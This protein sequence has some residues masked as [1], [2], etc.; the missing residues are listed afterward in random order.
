MLSHRSQRFRE[1]LADVCERLQPL[2]GCARRVLPFTASGTGGLEAVFVNAVEPGAHVLALSAGYFGERF[3]EIG[4]AHGAD[5]TLVR[6]PWGEAIEPQLLNAALRDAR[7][8][9]K[10]WDA[11]LLTHNETSTGVIHPLRDLCRVARETTDALVLVDAVSSVGA[12]PL[13]L[14][15]WGIDGAVTVSQKALMA[16]PGLTLL[17]VSDRLLKAARRRTTPRFYFDLGRMAE[18]VE[19]GTTAFTPAVSVVFALHESLRLI[20]LEG[21]DTVAARHREVAALCRRRLSAIGLDLIAPSGAESPTVTAGFVPQGQSAV[22]LRERLEEEHE[23]HI[24]T[25]RSGWKDD[26]LRVGHMGYVFSAD[27]EKMADSLAA[28]LGRVDE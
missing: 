21:F 13:Q 23:V 15:E 22:H 5:V 24:T 2:F 11:I 20:E 28:V 9:P 26:V 4:R 8:S 7:G 10:R 12:V 16:P 19:Q 6:R 27:V 17:A 25:G 14:E 1:L 18:A 3:A